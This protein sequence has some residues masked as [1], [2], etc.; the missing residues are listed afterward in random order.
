MKFRSTKI[1]I[2]ILCS[3]LSIQTWAQS[4]DFDWIKDNQAIAPE[5]L[6]EL[7]EERMPSVFSDLISGFNL[8]REECTQKPKELRDLAP[9]KLYEIAEEKSV[10]GE[11]CNASYVYQELMRQHPVRPYWQE[12]WIRQMV[13]LLRARD[14]L[15]V[16]NEAN[17]FMDENPGSRQKENVHFLLLTAVFQKMRSLGAKKSPEW[18]QFGLGFQREQ[19]LSNPYYLK[20]A[21]DSYLQSYPQGFYSELVLRF[22]STSRNMYASYHFQVSKYLQSQ[23]EYYAANINLIPILKYGPVVD[24]FPEALYE[25]VFN[26][27]AFAKKIRAGGFSMQRLLSW[28]ENGEDRTVDTEQMAIDLDLA[29]EQVLKQ[30]MENMPESPWTQRAR[31]LTKDVAIR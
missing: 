24:L 7:L 6:N 19:H 30:M 28:V 14:Y 11:H 25:T 3:F 26:Y 5:I 20:L 8:Y 23:G 21:Y 17:A 22:R 2:W 4:Q 13:E 9:R 18:I 27:R 15:G 16:I 10:R 31:E 1:G 12:A 29:A